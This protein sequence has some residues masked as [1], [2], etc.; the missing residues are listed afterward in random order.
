ML[1]PSPS[2]RMLVRQMASTEERREDHG[3]K[4]EKY[5]LQEGLRKLT[6]PVPCRSL[7]GWHVI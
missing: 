3:K 6:L 1:V 2:V 7:W 5:H 4:N